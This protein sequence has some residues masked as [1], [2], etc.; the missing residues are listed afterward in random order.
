[1]VTT[2]AAH[3]PVTPVGNPEKVAPIA[4]VV[5]KVISAIALLIQEVVFVPVA[6]A[7]NGVTVIVPEVLAGGHPPVVVTV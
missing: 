2:F 4:P 1:M 3:D 5:A 7:F 6:M